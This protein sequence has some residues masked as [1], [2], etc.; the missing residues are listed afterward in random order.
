MEAQIGTKANR[1]ESERELEMSGGLE[2]KL[3]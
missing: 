1:G 3:C 2:E